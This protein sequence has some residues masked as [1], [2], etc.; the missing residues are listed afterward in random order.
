MT[1]ALIQ[2]YT[3]KENATHTNGRF[4]KG[5]HGH[6]PLGVGVEGPK[7][8]KYLLIKYYVC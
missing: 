4:S 6:A 7:V 3:D 8:G 2:P 1:S 5:K